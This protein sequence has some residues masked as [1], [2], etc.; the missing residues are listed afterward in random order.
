MGLARARQRG[1]ARHRLLKTAFLM[2]ILVRRCRAAPA[3]FAPSASPIPACLSLSSRIRWRQPVD[4]LTELG[5]SRRIDFAERRRAVRDFAV[6]PDYE[7]IAI[8]DARARAE[9]A[10]LL[11][12]DGAGVG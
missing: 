8:V 2:A 7:Q 3:L 1:G 10:V 5:V 9:R 12:H 4:H 6:R 11:A